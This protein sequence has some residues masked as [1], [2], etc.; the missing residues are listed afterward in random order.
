LKLNGMVITVIPFKHHTFTH[1]SAAT[2]SISESRV[3]S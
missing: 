2:Y 3:T 1:G